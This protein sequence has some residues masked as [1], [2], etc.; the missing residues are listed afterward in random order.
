[1]AGR[2]VLASQLFAAAKEGVYQLFMSQ[3]APGSVL[4]TL[5]AAGGR[6]RQGWRRL[7]LPQLLSLVDFSRLSD[8]RSVRR[9]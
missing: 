4:S 8:C 9:R 1:M 2:R 6:L 3:M 7:A 5:P